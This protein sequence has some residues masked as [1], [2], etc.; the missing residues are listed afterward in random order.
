M[1]RGEAALTKRLDELTELHTDLVRQ[2]GQ[3]QQAT[4]KQFADL[5]AIVAQLGEQAKAKPPRAGNMAE[6]RLFLGDAE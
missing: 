2:I 3:Q 6:V 4:E 1:A 5:R